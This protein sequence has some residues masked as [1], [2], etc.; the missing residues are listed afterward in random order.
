MPG[1]TEYVNTVNE[2]KDRPRRGI[3]ESVINATHNSQST[4][5]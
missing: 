2:E 3:P 5:D 4:R 1:I